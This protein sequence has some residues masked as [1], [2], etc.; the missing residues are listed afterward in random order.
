MRDPVDEDKDKLA[1]RFSSIT[2]E[3][4]NWAMCDL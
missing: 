4:L 1:D 3:L 2:W